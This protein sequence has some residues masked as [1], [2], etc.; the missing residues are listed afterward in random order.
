MYSK[1]FVGIS[2]LDNFAWISHVRTPSILSAGVKL[3]KVVSFKWSL[4]NTFFRNLKANV[5]K[6]KTS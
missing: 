4:L 3:K 2:H 6:R 1:C 5:L